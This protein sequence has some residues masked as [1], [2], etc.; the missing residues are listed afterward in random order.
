MVWGAFSATGVGIL[1]RIEGIM[2]KEIYNDLLANVMLP[3][4]DILFG[5]ENW[6]FQ[7]DNDPKHTAKINKDFLIENEVP[8][9][10]WPAQSPDLNPH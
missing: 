7:Q 1:H 10:P 3:S 5:R 2:N 9:L 8:T 4:A 6:I